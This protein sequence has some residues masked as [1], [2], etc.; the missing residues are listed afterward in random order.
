MSV[1]NGMLQG[2]TAIVTGAAGGI[3]RVVVKGLLE[4]GASVGALDVDDAALANLQSEARKYHSTG[5]RIAHTDIADY[6]QCDRA[7]RKVI[8]Q[9]GGLDILI[10]NG[11]VGMGVIRDDHFSN[12]VRIEEITPEVWQ[13]VIAVNLSG[14]WNMTRAAIGNLLAQKWGRII[15]VTTSFFTMVRGRFHPYGPS[16]AGLEAMSCGHAQEFEGSGV[17]VNVVVPGGPADTPFV[18]DDIGVD[19]N[20]LIPPSVMVPPILWLCSEDARGINGN[21]YVA[22]HWDTSMPPAE[23]EKACRAP[24]AWPQL[25]QSPVWPGGKPKQ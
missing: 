25:A 18:P 14:A 9:F 21:R 8:D 15:N 2:K 4:A 5:L 19:R 20:D 16:K 6:A 12:L 24:A 11:A 3:G 17:T 10:N 23:A 1:E 13:R 7:I 22:A